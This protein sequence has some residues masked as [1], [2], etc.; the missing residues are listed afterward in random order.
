M[1]VVFSQADGVPGTDTSAAVPVRNGH[2]DISVLGLRASTTY[3]FR[4]VAWA[5][6]R[7]TTG[8]VIVFSTAS[9]PADL[10]SYSA[11]GTDPSPGFVVFASGPYAI[12]IDNSG[13]IVWYRRFPNSAGLAFVAQANGRYYARP[14]R[15]DPADA[16]Q[17]LELDPLGN[18]VRRLPCSGG[19]ISR[20]HD[21]IVHPDGSYWLM[22]D[23]T[24]TV[25]LSRQQ[26]Q[27]N[28]TVTGTAIHHIAPDGRVLFQWSPFDHLDITDLDASKRS[29]AT[30]NWTHGN[31]L[32]LDSDGNVVIS[33]RNLEEVTRINRV[34]GAVISRL[35]GKRNQFAIA[36]S[37]NPPFAQ[38]HSAR[39]SSA[40]EI[41]LLD[42]LGNPGE[43]RAERYTL[44]ATAMTARLTAS[45]GS[46]PSV[47]TAIGGSVQSIPGGRMLVSFGTAGR[48]EEYDAAGN[49]VWR[50]HGN[51]GYV[52]RAQR[53][54]SLY[55]PG[56]GTT[57]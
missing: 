50:I 28:A 41:I 37:T 13:R 38:Q 11:A 49:V 12:A 29:G 10:P 16:E 19:M 56:A 1:A 26:G 45:F 15:S 2:A 54:S 34:T 51:P 9:L 21:I 52:F 24:R 5:G 44:D 14:A 30:V 48:V 57:R 8:D 6:G 4:P 18:I 39:F 7:S 40:N 33:F 43:S 25:D 42:N 31:A 20:P 22:C 32:D 47:V 23:D 27:A 3:H 35:G 17:W 36:G 46:S 53:I 55:S